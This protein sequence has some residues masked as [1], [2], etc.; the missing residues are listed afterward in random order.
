VNLRYLDVG[1]YEP[2]ILRLNY[3]RVV[4]EINLYVYLFLTCVFYS[5]TIT[6]SQEQSHRL[7]E[8]SSC[9]KSCMLVSNISC[10]HEYQLHIF[11]S[12]S[13]FL[14]NNAMYLSLSLPYYIFVIIGEND[15]FGSMPSDICN[16][17]MGVG[18]LNTLWSD[19]TID[20][21]CCTACYSFDGLVDK[22][23]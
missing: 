17:T 3:H 12:L 8:I 4:D 20:C 10:S 9:Y 7:S 15:F 2:A 6:N 23:E 5:K 22:S 16:L 14:T 11:F 18:V 19:C 21:D 1:K 13:I